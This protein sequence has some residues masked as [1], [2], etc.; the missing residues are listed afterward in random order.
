M[1]KKSEIQDKLEKLKSILELLE[2]YPDFKKLFLPKHLEV[3]RKAL[4]NQTL[5]SGDSLLR[6]KVAL[7]RFNTKI[8]K[9][10][11]RPKS[12]LKK[13]KTQKIF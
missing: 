8:S 1:A 6:V 11:K 3:M 12:E 10:H 2:K 7:V 5:I 4:E 9:T 13:S